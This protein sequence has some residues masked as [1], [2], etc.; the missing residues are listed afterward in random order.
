VLI[1]FRSKAC[2][3]SKILHS[4][5]KEKSKAKKRA[6]DSSG[7]DKTNQKKVMNW[8]APEKCAFFGDFLGE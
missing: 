8:Q 6:R 5:A 1:G 2:A 3:A 4:S 7:I